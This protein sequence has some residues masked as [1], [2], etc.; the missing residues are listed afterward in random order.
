[1]NIYKIIFWVVWVVLLWTLIYLMTSIESNK[2]TI[3]D[4]AAPWDFSIWILEDSKDDFWSYMEDFKS[5]NPAFANKNIIVESF[6]DRE[7]YFQTLVSAISS[8]IAPDIFVMDN[9]EVSPLDNYA[10]WID[11]QIISPNDFRWRFA[12]RFSEDLIVWDSE[13]ENLEFLKGVPIW[14]E[15]LWIYYSR[16]YFLRPSELTSWSDFASEVQSV[17]DKQSKIVPIAMWNSQVS[18][19]WDIIT[20]LLVAEW[21]ESIFDTNQWTART[22]LSLYTSYGDKWGD[23]KYNVLTSSFGNKS[24]IEYFTEGDVAAM[25]WYPRDL[26]RISEIWYQKSFLFAAPFPQF[27][28]NEN[29]TAIK[30]NYFAMSKDSSAPDVWQAILAYM[31]SL[32]WQQKYLEY[33]PYYLSPELSIASE[34]QEKKII[35]D[36][37]IVYKNFVSEGSELISY[38]MWSVYNYLWETER[39][40]DDIDT[41]DTRFMDMRDWLICSSA[42]QTTLLN[43]SNSCK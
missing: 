7:I 27:A 28:G 22:A 40:V 14:Y 12:P 19:A 42:K 35:P 17:S 30:Y 2:N 34:K 5:S 9:R 32:E 4:R 23:N 33:F 43:L 18:H 6:D 24:D 41:L 20:S 11:P 15:T 13:D 39:I 3:P 16:K 25:V 29:K 26:L 38:N 8:G 37:N 1:M 31:S 36:Y 21:D 10:L